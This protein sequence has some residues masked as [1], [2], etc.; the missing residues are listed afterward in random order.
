MIA[1]GSLAYAAPEQIKSMTPLLD[2]AIDMW[3]YGV[4]VHAITV[5][6]LPF[7][8][9]FPPKLQFMILKGQWNTERCIARVDGEIAEVI[10]NC[11]QMS[12]RSRWTSRDVLQ[13]Q[14]LSLYSEED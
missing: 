13:S 2:T 4:V 7:H 8:D 14:W 6:E 12:P 5:G 3:S 1:G 9:H 10:L 11:L